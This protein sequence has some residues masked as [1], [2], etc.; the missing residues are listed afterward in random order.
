MPNSSTDRNSVTVNF[1]SRRQLIKSAAVAAALTSVEGR[2]Q[3]ADQSCPVEGFEPWGRKPI[4]LSGMHFTPYTS[5]ACWSIDRHLKDRTRF[6]FELR[7]GDTTPED[8]KKRN[9][10]ERAEFNQSGT[11]PTDREITLEFNMLVEEGPRTTAEW[12]ILT[13]FHQS[14]DPGDEPASPP[15]AQYVRPNDLFTIQS[16][17]YH[18]RPLILR[19]PRTVHYSLPNFP[20]GEWHHFKYLVRFSPFS[21][22]RLKCQINGLNVV[23]YSGGVSYLNTRGPYFKFGIYRQ[24]ARERL[25][26]QFS[27]VRLSTS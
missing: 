1:T 22:G 27:G 19:P 11:L 15:L 20:R 17:S 24:P 12:T 3:T 13:Q 9:I 14:P 10:S 2:A 23:D 6:R 25:S 21:D 16:R 4:E 18:L 8:A 26:V 7:P 5:G